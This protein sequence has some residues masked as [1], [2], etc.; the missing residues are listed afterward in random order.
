M[1]VREMPDGRLLCIHQTSHALMAAS[2]CRHWGNRD[3]ARPEPYDITLLAIAQHDNGWYEWEQQ[4]ELRPDGYPM[5]FIHG[6]QAET[7]L[8][9]WR[10]G[11]AR[12]W[13]QHP[14]AG[15]LV[16]NHAAYLYQGGLED[17]TDPSERRLI[18]AFLDEQQERQDL[19]RARFGQ[20]AAMARALR[21][22]VLESN[23]RLLQFGDSASLQVTIPW[24]S[25]RT[26]PRCPLDGE[27][28]FVSIEMEHGDDTITFDPWPFDVDHFDVT[29]HGRL[30]SQRRFDHAAAY[31]AALA[32][33][34]YHCLTWQVIRPE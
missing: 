30:L 34:P 14:Y 28:T 29:I 22:A 19:L 32:E 5:D 23:T 9:L 10:R 16:G 4:P 7:K 33:A 21:P 12:A 1:I 31:H 3:F 8:D 15:V 18:Q 2:F 17:V 24:A 13:A 6:P 25:R 26:F 20:D 11:V 27:G